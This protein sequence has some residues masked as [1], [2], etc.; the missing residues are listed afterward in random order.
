MYARRVA[1]AVE[2]AKKRA[3]SIM[4]PGSDAVPADLGTAGAKP[5]IRPTRERSAATP[6]SAGKRAADA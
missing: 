1:E 3:R 5:T 6:G 2:L 4:T